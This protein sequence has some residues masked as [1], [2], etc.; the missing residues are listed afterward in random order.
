MELRCSNCHQPTPRADAY[1]PNCGARMANAKR[2]IWWRVLL[3]IVLTVIV[4]VAE[5]IGLVIASC[6]A[7]DQRNP[8]LGICL[9]ILIVWIATIVLIF[10]RKRPAAGSTSRRR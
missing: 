7:T 1:C 3:A 4:V 9:A 8:V 6:A 10:Y 2:V 5:L